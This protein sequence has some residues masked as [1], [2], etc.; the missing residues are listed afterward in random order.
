VKNPLLAS[1]V[2][3][4]IL[5][6]VGAVT[7]ASTAHAN[8]CIAYAAGTAED[9]FLIQ[10][11]SNLEC[12]YSNSDY[13][14]VHQ[15]HFKQTANLDMTGYASWT[16]GIGT[17]AKPFDGVFDGNGFEIRNLNFS[18]PASYLG[19][20]GYGASTSTLKDTHVVSSQITVN[21][22]ITTNNLGL[23][24]GFT[25]GTVVDSSATGS[26]TVNS[27]LS[28]SKIGGLVGEAVN[29][30][31]SKSSAN[32]VLTF[33]GDAQVYYIGGVV[34]LASGVEI[35]QVQ[36]AGSLT[37]NNSSNPVEYLGGIV[38]SLSSSALTNSWTNMSVTS[39]SALS[40][41]YIGSAVGVMAS[42]TVDKIYSTG[43]LSISSM[44][45]SDTR[46]ALLGRV[47]ST[48]TISNSLWNKDSPGLNISAV[49]SSGVGALT[50]TG[51]I[52]ITATQM[53]SYRSYA[54]TAFVTQPWDIRNG[55]ENLPGVIWGICSGEATPYLLSLTSSQQCA[56]SP[57][58][59]LSSVELEN[60][61]SFTVSGVNFTPNGLITIEL[62]SVTVVLSSITANSAGAFTANVTIPTSTSGGTHNIV[63]KDDVNYFSVTQPI[64]V[65]VV[66][67]DTG[68]ASTPLV[69]SLVL[70]CSGLGLIAA[71]RYVFNEVRK[72]NS[73]SSRAI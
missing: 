66:L 7:D 51:T 29:N 16:T 70:I 43:S 40:A 42:S 19:F 64:N 53:K 47:T 13:Y 33:T 4:S 52:G 60:G 37:A 5:G 63:V 48:S 23:L 65:T 57:A 39:Q 3:A 55:S 36:S 2:L 35:S 22:V 68:L 30:S 28:S 14:W 41:D 69:I 6:M 72:Q 45:G 58:I 38:G 73:S 49:G 17:Q 61:S 67:A 46:G 21:G 24:S 20:I 59:T 34:G 26:I 50:M 15:Y 32:V 71:R 27:R 56:A 62:H 44:Y 18:G 54:S 8:G 31:I 12:L 9:P 10:N 25:A 11:E 1:L